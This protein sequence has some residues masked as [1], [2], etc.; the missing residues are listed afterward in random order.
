[1]KRLLTFFPQLQDNV[2]ISPL[3]KMTLDSRKV[4]N[5]DLFIALKGHNVDGRTFIPKAIEQGASLILAEA[6]EGVQAVKIAK[7]CATF[8]ETALAN[9]GRILCQPKRK[10]NISGYYRH[11]WQN[12][13]SS[14]VSAMA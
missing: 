9:R 13:N 14:A 2:Q 5:G 12:D 3:A 10:I 7:E 4:S 6:D 8:A 1:M 11:K